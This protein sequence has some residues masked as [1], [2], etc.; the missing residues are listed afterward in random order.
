MG[1]FALRVPDEM[2]EEMDQIRINRSE[3]LRHSIH[4]PLQEML[5]IVYK[6][7]IQ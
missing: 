6:F 2:K 3:Y 4:I 7:P 1:M 5:N